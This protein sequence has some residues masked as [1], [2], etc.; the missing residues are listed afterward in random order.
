M[1][2]V[3]H[4][5]EGHVTFVVAMPG[6]MILDINVDGVFEGNSRSRCVTVHVFLLSLFFQL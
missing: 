2:L 3:P 4:T 1:L 6:A 5:N